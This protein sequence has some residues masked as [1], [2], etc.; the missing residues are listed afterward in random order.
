MDELIADFKSESKTLAGQ[1]LEILE[2]IE[3]DYSQFRRL[4]EYGQIVDRIMGTAKSLA[5]GIPELQTILGPIGN[6]GELCK[7]VAYKGS[8]VANNAELYNIVVALLLDATEMMQEM[9]ENMG[10]G[11]IDLKSVLNAT[12][13]DRLR[14]LEQKFPAHLRAS[15]GPGGA[16]AGA[17]SAT[18][19]LNDLLK[20]FGIS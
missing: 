19:N 13:V 3:G 15:V 7:A 10:S 4:E 6:Y 1:L 17:G 14:W 20:S 16:S 2:A 9:I 8:Q 5:V 18:A 12:F 11:K